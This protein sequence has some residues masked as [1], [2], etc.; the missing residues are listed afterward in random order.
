M[1][2]TVSIEGRLTRD[3][4]I[5]KTGNGTSYANFSLANERGFGDNKKTNFFDVTV[6]G[7]S[8]ER[9]EKAKVAKGSHVYVIGELEQQT[10]EKDGQKRRAVKVKVSHLGEW[11]Y[12]SSGKKPDG[13]S[14]GSPGGDEFTP[15]DTDDDLPFE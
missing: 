14:G 13:A 5:G 12:I 6:W 2:N 15:V 10:Y 3:L 4:E 1:L 11:G 9:M 8:A 7:E